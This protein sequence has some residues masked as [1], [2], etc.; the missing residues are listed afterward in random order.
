MFRL[1]R[2]ALD[3]LFPQNEYD[4]YMPFNP[5]LEPAALAQPVPLPNIP[6]TIGIEKYR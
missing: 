5:R 3:D 2:K 1:K 4:P 6:T